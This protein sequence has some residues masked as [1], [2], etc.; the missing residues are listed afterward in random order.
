MKRWLGWISIAWLIALTSFALFAYGQPASRPSLDDRARIIAQGLRCP[1]CQ[2]E[3]V[4]DSPSAIS[5]AI[6]QEIRQR[7]KQGETPAQVRAYFVS[8]YGS[9][10]LLA[11][12]QSGVADLAWIAPPLLLFGGA[13]LLIT[14]LFAWRT[15]GRRPSRTGD[16]P[17]L[18][19]VRAE[20]A[21][22]TG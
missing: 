19:R 13:G 2:G 21:G 15:E 9:W 18:E 5:Q 3:S 12:P 8:R 14:L 1:V 10:I 16:D 7:L 20:L 17:Y 11:P 22:E 6:R 4:A